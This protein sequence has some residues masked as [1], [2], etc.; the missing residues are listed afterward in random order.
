M[1]SL[2]E[3]LTEIAFKR[4]EV[5]VKTISVPPRLAVGPEWN[6]SRLKELNA[7]FDWGAL[8]VVRRDQFKNHSTI[9]YLW[10]YTRKPEGTAK[11]RF[12]LRGDV[13]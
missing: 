4:Q 3:D 10:V 8:E 9:P 12:C 6:E 11:S 1:A 7:W 5:G 13:E 2:D